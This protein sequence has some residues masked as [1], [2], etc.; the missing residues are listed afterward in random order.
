MSN[1]KK[2]CVVTGSRAEYGLLKLIMKEI[3]ENKELDLQIIATGSH[4]SSDFGNTYKEIEE[5]GFLINKKIPILHNQDSSDEIIQ[6][7][8]DATILYNKA[9][10]ELAPDMLVVLG[11]RYEIFAAVFTAYIL[12]IPISH[13]HGGEVTEGAYDEAFRHSIT[14][15]S[16]LH[17]VTTNDYMMRVIQLGEEPDRVFN[18]GA[19]GLEAIKTVN[20]LSKKNLENELGLT[21]KEKNILVTYHPET[22]NSQISPEE[23]I[24]ILL[25]AIEEF[26]DINFIFTKA[27][28]DTGGMKING[29]IQKFVEEKNNCTLFSSLGQKKYL[30]L[31]QYVDG[32]VGNS[33]SGIIEVPSFKISTVNIGKRQKGRVRSR[34]VI[35]SELKVQSIKA[36]IL[37]LYDENFRQ[38]SQ[39]GV[40]PYEAGETSKSI[41]SKINEFSKDQVKIKSFYDLS[42]QRL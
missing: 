14:K 22:L 23:Q 4:L 39:E 38:I 34:S 10:K 6:S 9:F 36:A 12:N 1:L 26:E 5:D 40:N 21:L 25:K 19:P 2:I 13:I 15:M 16:Y 17:F 31:L 30:S 7:I 3:S 29:K 18:F 27:N 41:V 33:S 32:V 8:S 28:A 35:D 24:E 11:D 42:E 37:S 20:L